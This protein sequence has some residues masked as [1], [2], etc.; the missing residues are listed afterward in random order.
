MQQENTITAEEA[1]ECA[2]GC[3]Y[4]VEYGSAAFWLVLAFCV[5][6]VERRNR[7]E[8]YRNRRR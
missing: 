6:W 2:A 8:A 3:A 1:I 4:S 7:Q 5:A